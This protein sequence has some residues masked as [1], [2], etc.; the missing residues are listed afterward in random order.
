VSEHETGGDVGDELARGVELA[1]D[2]A[3]ARSGLV[4]HDV[5]ALHTLM[6]PPEDPLDVG[7]VSESI[8]E[9]LRR[10]PALFFNPMAHGA[11]GGKGRGRDI[12]PLNGPTMNDLLAAEMRELRGVE[13]IE[14]IEINPE[15]WTG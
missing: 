9:T 7:E 15:G 12:E 11:D 2:I 8:F 4:C 14:H 6:E 10:F 13:V 1:L 5:D 3:R